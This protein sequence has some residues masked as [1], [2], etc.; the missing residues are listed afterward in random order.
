MRPAIT[1]RLHSFVSYHLFCIEKS[2]VSN[3]KYQLIL[4]QNREELLLISVFI[5]S[6]FSIWKVRRC[7]ILERFF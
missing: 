6:H 2:S 4:R 1:G 5:Q 3:G 7:A